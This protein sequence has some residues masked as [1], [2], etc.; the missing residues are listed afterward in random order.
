MPKL[1]LRNKGIKS[2]PIPPADLYLDC[3]A[4]YNPFHD[5]SCEGSGD[6]PSVQALVWKHS[7]GSVRAMAKIVEEAIT[8]IPVRRREAAD[9]FEEP[10]VIVC[11][12][13]HGI[14]RSRATKYL[15]ADLLKDQAS[16]TIE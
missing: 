15:L 2:G 13:A 16:I 3:R 14:H 1:I 5:L 6:L 9:P 11:L 8:R 7:E 4:L 12:C 10:F